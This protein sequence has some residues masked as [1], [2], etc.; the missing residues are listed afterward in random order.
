MTI[1]SD[2]FQNNETVPTPYTCQ[3]SNVNPPLEFHDVPE[4]AKSLILTVEDRDATPLP[5]IHW[6]VFN[7][8]PSVTRVEENAIPEGGTEGYANGGSP[9][10]EGP[11]PK[12]FQGIHH[13]YFTVYALNTILDVAPTT[14][15]HDIKQV[16][17][18]H[19]IEKAELI[20]IAEGTKEAV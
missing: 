15:K 14:S 12:Y 9:G 1:T 3:R 20:G 18:A 8:P 4:G 13:Y 7:I 16:L 11:C 10:Y 17:T 5:W 6:F 2:T 19:V